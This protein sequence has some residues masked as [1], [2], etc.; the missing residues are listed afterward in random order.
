MRRW[1]RTL[2][3]SNV[4]RSQPLRFRN[5]VR[6][7]PGA[8]LACPIRHQVSAP[9]AGLGKNYLGPMTS[10]SP[11]SN[12]LPTPIRQ[13]NMD[14]SL[15]CQNNLLYTQEPL[16]KYKPGGYHPVALG[17][18][19]KNGRYEIHH[20]LGYGGFSTVWLA[21]DKELAQKPNHFAKPQL[22]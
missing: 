18:T 4:M 8:I 13:S 5:I 20:K 10:S 11:H 1:I 15:F 2:N 12:C 16:S 19:F 9:P 14:L 21:R 3:Q 22:T 6:H 7:I 17:D